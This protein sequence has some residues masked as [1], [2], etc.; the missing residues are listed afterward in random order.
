MT[1]MRH[2]GNMSAWT[3]KRVFRMPHQK[4]FDAGNIGREKQAYAAERADNSTTAQSG[5]GSP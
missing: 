1:V 3:K 2:D 4:G 5:K